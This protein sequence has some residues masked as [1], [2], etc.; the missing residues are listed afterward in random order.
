MIHGLRTISPDNLETF[1]LKFHETNILSWN[2]FKSKKK[3]KKEEEKE[4]ST[5]Q[6]Y[7]LR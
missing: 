7:P 1:G 3:K 2:F 5:S 4:K 6:T